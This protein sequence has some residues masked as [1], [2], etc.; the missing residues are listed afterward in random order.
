MKAVIGLFADMAQAETAVEGF[1][2]AGFAEEKIG[3]MARGYLFKEHL[4][5]NA[6]SDEVLEKAGLGVAVGTAAGGLLGFLAT[7]ISLVIPVLGP[8][9]AAGS[10]VPIITGATA[11]AVYGGLLGAFLGMD[12]P[13]A[14]A[15]F[16]VDKLESGSIMVVVNADDEQAAEAWSIMRSFQPIQ[17]ATL[18]KGSE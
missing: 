6:H 10:L 13:E 18:E 15:K 14:E 9:L 5:V 8:I 2:D 4:G 7:G 11:G 3:V 1:K 12:V 16:Y 17:P